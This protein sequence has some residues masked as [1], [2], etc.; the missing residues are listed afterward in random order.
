MEQLKLDNQLCFPFYSVSRLVI[1]K[2]QPYL[3]KLRITYP[4]YLVLLVLWETD[5]MPVNDIAKRLILQTNTV[6]PLLKRMEI[7]GI[8]TRGKSAKDERKVIVS[9]TEKGKQM[10]QQASEI[11]YKLAE[12]MQM[13]QVELQNLHRTLY[14]LIDQLK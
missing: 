8:I 7:Q 10:K 12:G 1:R 5:D 6:T 4:Q 9:L 13:S 2:Y 11:P 14:Q 3:D